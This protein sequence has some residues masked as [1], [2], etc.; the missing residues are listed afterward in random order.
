MASGSMHQR[1]AAGMAGGQSDAFNSNHQE[2]LTPV[3]RE[4]ILSKSE[5]LHI[6]PR[7][8]QLHDAIDTTAYRSFV[9]GTAQREVVT[10]DDVRNIGSKNG[11]LEEGQLLG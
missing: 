1:V 4:K 10:V 11:L 7:L 8:T 9:E 2:Q 3:H 6:R 5:P